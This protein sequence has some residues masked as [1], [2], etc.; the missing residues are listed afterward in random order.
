LQNLDS[1]FHFGQIL[2]R[3]LD[4]GHKLVSSVFHFFVE[5]EEGV[6]SELC[7]LLLLRQIKDQKF[8]HLQ[9][10]LRLTFLGGS[11]G[12]RARH[13]LSDGGQKLNFFDPLV[14]LGLVILN[15][16]LTLLDIVLQLGSLDRHLLLIETKL[17]KLTD[18]DLL[19]FMKVLHRVL[20]FLFIL[21]QLLC[22]LG[23]TCDVRL[24]VFHLYHDSV[25]VMLSTFA[26]LIL[27]INLLLDLL[28]HVL[29][30]LLTRLQVFYAH[31]V[32]GISLRE[33]LL[34]LLKVLDLLADLVDL[35][36]KVFDLRL[37]GLAL[38]PLDVD[39]VFKSLQCLLLALQNT[40]LLLALFQDLIKLLLQML[41]GLLF[42]LS[43]NLA[44]TNGFVALFVVADLEL[45]NVVT[46][47]SLLAVEIGKRLLVLL[48]RVLL[49]F[50]LILAFDQRLLH[51]GDALAHS[52]NLRLE[53]LFLLLL[54]H[55]EVTF[56]LVFL[57]LES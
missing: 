10:F 14:L 46:E 30:R 35:S 15:L 38:L 18:E 53:Q 40:L 28:Q 42:D 55:R 16:L 17:D 39:H 32:L 25:V 47:L 8:L 26:F 33:L 6:K 54:L 24:Q 13:F 48:G 56:L 43:L 20:I 49:F 23:R 11:C 12:G 27:H 3:A 44:L 19:L 29:L 51:L 50:N 22:E 5:G 36:V 1:F 41:N 57:V 52:F 31:G 2:G 9:L 21:L 4:L 37:L 7:L 34:Q 45:L